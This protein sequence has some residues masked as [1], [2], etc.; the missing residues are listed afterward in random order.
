MLKK[1]AYLFSFMRLSRKSS[2]RSGAGGAVDGDRDVGG[3]ATRN[4]SSSSGSSR[5]WRL[6]N[7]SAGLRWKRK[8]AFSFHLWLVDGILFKI[9]SFFE[10]VFLLSNLAFF[11]LCCGCHI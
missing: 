6:K 5:R 2:S 1:P 8:S 7:M 3:G 11:Y 10:A 4:S 9:L